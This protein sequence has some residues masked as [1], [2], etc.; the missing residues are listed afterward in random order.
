MGLLDRLLGRQPD[1]T[2]DWP[3]SVGDLPTVSVKPFKLG[4]LRLGDSVDV[5]RFLGRPDKV[6]RSKVAGAYALLYVRWGLELE[7]EDHRLADALFLIGDTWLAEEGTP[8]CEPRL[9]DGL[10]LT[11]VTTA[12]RVVQ[13]FGEATRRDEDDDGEVTLSYENGEEFMDFEFDEA[14]RLASWCIFVDA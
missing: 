13:R 6:R 5:A 4:S 1:P 12:D 9:D 2:L 11:A 14:G 7:F 10:R 3:E 8:R